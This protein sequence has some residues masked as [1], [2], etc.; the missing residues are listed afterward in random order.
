MTETVSIVYDPIRKKLRARASGMWV[1]FPRALR[2]HGSVYE[3]DELIPDG[4]GA[5]IA[6]GR[7]ARV[8]GE[9]LHQRQR[10]DQ[11]LD[12]A[13]HNYRNPEAFGP[14]DE[15]RLLH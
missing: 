6:C 7:I 11:V 1:R 15:F 8:S 9:V 13:R 5:L 12:G 3:V 14:G 2:E 4:R 10:I